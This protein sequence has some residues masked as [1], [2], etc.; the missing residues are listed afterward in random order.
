MNHL[1]AII[2]AQKRGEGRGIA[3]I[4]SAHP[5]VL[6]SA[7][8]QAEAMGT[9]ALIEATCNQVNQFGG[10]TGMRPADFVRYISELAEQV[11]LERYNL[12]LGGDHL[13]PTPW[14]V[15]PAA[16]AMDKSKQMVRDYV[17][18]GFRKIHLDA[19]M[20]LGDDPPGPLP[21]DVAAARTAELAQVAEAALPSGELIQLRY[22]IGTEVPIAG[23]LQGEGEQPKVTAVSDLTETLEKS[24]AVFLER[25]LEVAWERVIAVVVQ[26]G[27]EYGN[28]FIWDYDPVAA[29]PLARFSEGQQQWVYEAHSTDYQRPA[30]LRALVRDHFAV[31]KVGPALTFALREALFGLMLIEN[32]LFPSQECSH[33][34]E[35]LETA[36][37]A[38]PQHW[39]K[40]Y[41]GP[42]AKQ[43]MARKYSFSDRSRYYWPVAAVRA[44]VQQL[45][46]NLERQPLPLALVSQYLP[47]AYERI[48]EGGVENR[49]QAI[50]KDRIAA[51]LA[52]YQLAVGGDV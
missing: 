42:A 4:C 9:P 15:E 21:V 18:A 30:A 3:S 28:D 47:G 23:G 22:V 1:D 25:G 37:L 26:P 31:L 10:Y 17:Q 45:M 12:I 39:E 13:G 40:H 51:V 2:Q 52:S 27:V 48:R 7:L 29:A 33:L 35:A 16:Q 20:R 8:E 24:R 34:W 36:M 5:I 19:S 32:E 43:A 44:A 38:D 41:R 46:Q 11:G 49:P 14:Q 50:V 6:E